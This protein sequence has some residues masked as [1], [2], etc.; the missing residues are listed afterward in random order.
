MARLWLSGDSYLRA[1][2]ELGSA[3]NVESALDFDSN[4][5][6]VL[7]AYADNL[8]KYDPTTHAVTYERAQDSSAD[9]DC[10]P[11]APHRLRTSCAPRRRVGR[12]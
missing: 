7:A 4:G 1:K 2:H 3:S 9:G 11:R 6:P 10:A 12:L 5:D 8:F